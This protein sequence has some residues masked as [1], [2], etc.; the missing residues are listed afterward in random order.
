MLEVL[1]AL[2]CIVAMTRGKVAFSLMV[3]TMYYYTNWFFGI[4]TSN[5][6]FYHNL[7]DV[8]N[9]L[10]LFI[11]FSWGKD[12][13]YRLQLSCKAVGYMYICLKKDYALYV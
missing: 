5:L 9:I 1:G 3:L 11:V 4:N 8:G 12:T 7:S 13:A 10:C 6:V 2:V